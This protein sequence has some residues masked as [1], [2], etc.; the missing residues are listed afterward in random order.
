MEDHVV[1]EV[2]SRPVNL[3]SEDIHL[4]WDLVVD[5]QE[6]SDSNLASRES[7]KPSTSRELSQ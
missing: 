2:L 6:S 7:L 1:K 3:Q 5:R 4:E